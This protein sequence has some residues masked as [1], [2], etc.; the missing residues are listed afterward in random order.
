MFCLAMLLPCIKVFY[1]TVI[2]HHTTYNFQ[3]E[4]KEYK[5]ENLNYFSNDTYSFF[6]K[7]HIF[8]FK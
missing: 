7:I 6:L 8:K 1:F 2:I 3:F 4:I 5:F